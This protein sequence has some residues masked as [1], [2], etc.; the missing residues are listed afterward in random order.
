LGN[1]LR[2]RLRLSKDSSKFEVAE[3]VEVKAEL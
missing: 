3:Q 2:L 1:R